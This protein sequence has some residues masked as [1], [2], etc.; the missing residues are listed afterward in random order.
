[1]MKSSKR[2]G[3]LARGT[4]GHRQRERVKHKQKRTSDRANIHTKTKERKSLDTLHVEGQ[5]ERSLR[6]YFVSI[7]IIWRGGPSKI[8]KTMVINLS[9]TMVK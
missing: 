8:S 9:E 4:R 1:M 7:L 3:P 6:V 2:T 5:R